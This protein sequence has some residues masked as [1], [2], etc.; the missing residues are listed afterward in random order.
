[1]IRVRP[2][3][4]EDVPRMME[5]ARLSATAAFWEQEAYTSLFAAERAPAYVVLVVEEQE[6]VV[7]FLAGREVASGEWE[8]ENVAVNAG[9]R[10][11]GLG[12]RLMGEFLDLVRGRG[13]AEVYLEMRESNRAARALY[14]KW[15]FREAGR[16]KAYYQH[17][18]ED[19]VVLKFSFS[20]RE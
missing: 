8:I 19:A 3:R 15:A 7:G 16:R 20:E 2:A 4:S 10:R 1:M 14:E 6:R 11:R 12:S 5:I 17:P 9:A 13:G 18:S